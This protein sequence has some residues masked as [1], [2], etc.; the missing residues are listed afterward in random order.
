M[1]AKVQTELQ[2]TPSEAELAEIAEA[3]E[4]A[5]FSDEELGAIRKT[6]RDTPR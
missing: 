3:F 6:R 5:E 1:T 4:R 2:R